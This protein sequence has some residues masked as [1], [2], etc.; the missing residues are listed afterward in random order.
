MTEQI[1]A[2]RSPIVA[3]LASVLVFG[4][5]QL[6]NN[7]PRKLLALFAMQFIVLGLSLFLVVTPLGLVAAAL[8]S[9]LLW[10]YTA[11]DAVRS[12]STSNGVG[13]FRWYHYGL[14][15]LFIWSVYSIISF[16]MRA[17]F[18]DTYKPSFESMKPSIRPGDCLIAKKY[19]VN[20]SNLNRGERKK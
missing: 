18:F 3:F 15:F 16:E 2:K 10:L 14:Y 13:S 5:G 9:F 17:H 20:L 4:L 12:S 19:G 11:I 8:L 1:E 7:Q 6:Y